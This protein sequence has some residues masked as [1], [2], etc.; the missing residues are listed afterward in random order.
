MLPAPKHLRAFHAICKEGSMKR[1]GD[2]LRRSR[3]SVS[4]A[5]DELESEIGFSL[6][7][8]NAHGMLLTEFGNILYRRVDF[9]FQEMAVA[10]RSLETLHANQML[11]P[12][13]PIFSLAVSQQRINI[14]LAFAQLRHMSAAAREL[15]VSQ[16]AVSMALRD[17]E[18]SIGVPLYEQVAGTFR[19]T[20]SGDILLNHLKRALV[21]L[22]LAR[23][24][25]NRVKGQFEGSIAVGALP[26][27]GASILPPAISRLLASYPQLKI[28]THEGSFDTLVAGLWCGDL[29][30]VVGALQPLEQHAGLVS[31]R[32]FDDP[33]VVVA[34]ADHPL[35][36]QRNVTLEDV[37][38]AGWVLPAGGTPTREALFSALQQKGVN[39]PKVSVESSDASTIRG[40]LLESNLISAGARRL[41]HHDLQSGALVRLADDY[42][43]AQRSIGILTRTQAHSSPLAQLLMDEIRLIAQSV[44]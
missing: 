11:S 31:E 21:Q 34:R 43:I 42:P 10:R 37:V 17:L 32:L 16:P 19:F 2:V 3:S 14:F 15:G 40:L 25:M 23:V 20:R 27:G 22:R 28:S 9:A 39:C 26:F 12:N 41:F 30:L 7:E 4:H 44:S 1:A 33:I 24:E 6:F 8:R 5:I 29:D 18:Q 38:K 36:Q 35:A 13:A